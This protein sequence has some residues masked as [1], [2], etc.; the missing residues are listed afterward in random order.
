MFRKNISPR[1]IFLAFIFNPHL[2][3]ILF[4]LKSDFIADA[5]DRSS[6]AGVMLAVNDNALSEKVW[7]RRDAVTRPQSNRLSPRIRLR[8]IVGEALLKI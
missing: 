4:S 3:A 7:K 8:K 5:L 1:L 6:L 2:F